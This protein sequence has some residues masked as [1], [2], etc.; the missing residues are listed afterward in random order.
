[1]QT[2]NTTTLVE[3]RY[4]EASVSNPTIHYSTSYSI[5]LSQADSHTTA[6]KS[7]SIGMYIRSQLFFTYSMCASCH[8]D[9]AKALLPQL[10][11]VIM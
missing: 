3:Y 5:T 2:G 4:C 9:T 6:I 8:F 11:C 1:M 7:Y 10:T